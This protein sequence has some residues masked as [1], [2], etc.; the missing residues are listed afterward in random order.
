MNPKEFIEQAK[1]LLDGAGKFGATID[2]P[3]KDVIESV[4]EAIKQ[5][6]EEPLSL[7]K[8]K[9]GYSVK[10][11][12]YLLEF[13]DEFVTIIYDHEFCKVDENYFEKLI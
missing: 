12:G 9:Q 13:S 6:D 8:I 2:A 4:L 7:S 5:K 1:A 3:T 10:G 11:Q